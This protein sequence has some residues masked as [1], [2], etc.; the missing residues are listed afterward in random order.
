MNWKIKTLF[1]CLG[2][3]A[4]SGCASITRPLNYSVEIY[5]KGKEMI[6]VDPFLITD[7]PVS[8]V[9]V[10]E[11]YSHN[12][13]A[14]SP[15]YTKPFQSV[16]IAWR[17]S[18]TGT[19]GSAQATLNLPKEFTKERGSEIKFY[20]FPEEQKVDVTYDIFN[21]KTG[22]TYIIRQPVASH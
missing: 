15:F 22:E 21:P 20:I 18:T 10:G 17:S 12:S 13:K 8:T 1:I 19:R 11:V 6:V 9:E 4:A 5:N 16:N 2:A 3:F 7:E 14:M